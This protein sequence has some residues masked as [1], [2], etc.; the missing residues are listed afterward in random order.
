MV[1]VGS[2]LGQQRDIVFGLLVKSAV[3][4][5]DTTFLTILN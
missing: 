1:M 5:I 3:G 2:E 4:K